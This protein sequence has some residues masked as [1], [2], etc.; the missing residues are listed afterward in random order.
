MLFRQIVTPFLFIAQIALVGCA[1]S[2]VPPTPVKLSEVI[3]E[4]GNVVIF[5]AG[6]KPK[7]VTARVSVDGVEVGRLKNGQYLDIPIAPGQREIKLHFNRLHF[8]DSHRQTLFV[9][10]GETYHLQLNSRFEITSDYINGLSSEWIM[11]M[12]PGQERGAEFCCDPVEVN[13][14]YLNE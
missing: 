1:S 6:I 3:G 11:F 10:P 5:R 7:L 8:M 14:D 12:E 13:P 2:G 9:R 4:T